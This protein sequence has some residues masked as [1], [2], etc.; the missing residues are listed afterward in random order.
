MSNV[1]LTPISELS[2][3]RGPVLVLGASGTIDTPLRAAVGYR[4]PNGQILA[5]DGTPFDASGSP[6]LGFMP[7][8]WS[9]A[10]AEALILSRKSGGMD[11]AGLWRGA[12]GLVDELSEAIGPNRAMDRLASF[13]GLRQKGYR[14]P[15]GCRTELH[16]L[17]A[18]AAEWMSGELPA[19]AAIEA[20]RRIIDGTALAE[21]APQTNLPSTLQM[22][23]RKEDQRP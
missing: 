1:Q 17:R 5:L 12:T 23:N 4:A 10:Q 18:L 11:E 16:E 7:L 3:T 6:A 15:E 20:G 2:C 21:E 8:P 19:E 14:L 22:A 13:L 9:E